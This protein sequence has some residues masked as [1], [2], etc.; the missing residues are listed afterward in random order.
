MKIG[1]PNSSTLHLN[2]NGPSLC[3]L[4]FSRVVIGLVH[5]WIV[6]VVP[7]GLQLAW[8]LVDFGVGTS[9][10]C[11]WIIHMPANFVQMDPGL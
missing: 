8:K 11:V 7:G 9:P 4:W 5:Q 6:V 3:G 1:T 2:R 10:M